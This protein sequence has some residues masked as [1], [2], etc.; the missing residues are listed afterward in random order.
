MS[1]PPLPSPLTGNGKARQSTQWQSQTFL[2]SPPSMP[3]WR[4][5]RSLRPLL[6]RGLLVA[7]VCAASLLL[8][9]VLHLHG[10]E[11][12]SSSIARAS[13]FRGELSEARDSDDGEAA[14]AAVEAGGGAS[15]T[16][17]ACAT[18][19]R[20]GE[21]AA[22]RGSPEAAS[23]RVRELIRRHFLLHGACAPRC[24]PCASK[25]RFDPL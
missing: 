1:F 6:R 18:V 13:P 4:R 15:T 25:R 14:A 7:A 22:G 21:E 11:L 12:P 10:P 8:L 3:R 17:A 23:L 19:E 2:A 16:G 9:V 20:M 24:D 5:G